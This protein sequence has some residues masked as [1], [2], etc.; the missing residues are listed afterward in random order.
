MPE[1]LAPTTVPSLEVMAAAMLVI[2]FWAAVGLVKPG[3]VKVIAWP[4]MKFPAE[5]EIVST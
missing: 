2:A 5:N 3:M 4:P 1:T